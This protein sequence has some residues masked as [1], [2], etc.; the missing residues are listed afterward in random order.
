V[1]ADLLACMALFLLA[2][3]TT[4]SQAKEQ[5]TCNGGQDRN[6]HACPRKREL[7]PHNSA[8]RESTT[9]NRYQPTPNWQRRKRCMNARGKVRRGLSAPRRDTQTLFTRSL[10]FR[11]GSDR[12]E[13]TRIALRSSSF[14]HGIAHEAAPRICGDHVQANVEVTRAQEQV[15]AQRA[16]ALGRRC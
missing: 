16:D 7:K 5:K 2:L 13:P 1:L 9:N 12:S 4:V 11:S 3:N 6:T 10:D 14:V 8:D 15:R